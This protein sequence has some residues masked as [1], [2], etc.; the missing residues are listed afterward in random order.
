MNQ[1]L[2]RK[3]GAR[4]KGLLELICNKICILE[5]SQIKNYRADEVQ[6]LIQTIYFIWYLFYLYRSFRL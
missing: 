5:F 6:K 1:N 3:W 2:Y 4:V